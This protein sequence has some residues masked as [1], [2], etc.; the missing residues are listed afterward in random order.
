MFLNKKPSTYFTYCN[1]NFGTVGTIIE[2][3]T[4]IR[5]DEYIKSKVLDPMNMDASFNVANF[6]NTND[7]AAVYRYDNNKWEAQVD[8][9]G[10]QFPFRNLSGY[11]VGTNGFVFSPQGGC[12]S[13]S[14]DLTHILTMLYNEGAYGD[15]QIL[16]PEYAKLMTTLQWE[17]NGSNGDI[18]DGFVYNYAFWLYKPNGI[19]ARYHVFPGSTC[20]GHIG[21]A[22]GLKSA[23]FM[24]VTWGYGISIIF[25]GAKSYEKGSTSFDKQTEDIF[26]IAYSYFVENA[27]PFDSELQVSGSIDIKRN[28]LNIFIG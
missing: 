13:S 17:Y 10:S 20:V 16:S 4:G 21:D 15:N 26:N 7:I 6:A 27:K 5:F 19:P 24:D 1:A 25:N 3:V 2:R 8:D 9:Y 18:G 11:A 12:K 23:L 22:Y 28:N 14:Q